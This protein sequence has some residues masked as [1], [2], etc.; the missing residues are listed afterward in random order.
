MKRKKKVNSI[1]RK[2]AKNAGFSLI[3][4][5]LAIVI[6]GLVA[7]PILQIFVTSAQINHRSRK[8]MAATDVAATTM[9]Y[10]TSL[11]FDDTTDGIK[12]IMADTN[13][14]ERIP[15]LFTASGIALPVS[16]ST[17]DA[18]R[19]ELVA[20][21]SAVS[22]NKVFINSISG[23]N[24]LG[25]AFNSVDYNNYEFDVIVWFESNN[26]G[27]DDFYTYDVTI[28]VYDT[29]EVITQDPDGNDVVSTAHFVEK[30]ITVEGAVAN[31]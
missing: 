9:E 17:L 7:A 14:V 31:K 26:T 11:K 3:E 16:L 24:F 1:V 23:D 15:G 20:S 25:V 5:L 28:E 8:I 2:F 12:V 10:L 29:G 6:L 18:F 30:L 19:N 27:S 13:N 4:V 22:G 21:Y